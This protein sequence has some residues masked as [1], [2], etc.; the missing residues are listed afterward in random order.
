MSFNFFSW[1][2][3]LRYAV[4]ALVAF[5]GFMMVFVQGNSSAGRILLMIAAIGVFSTM[6]FD[7]FDKHMRNKN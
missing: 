1:W 5:W 7:L 4:C 2:K 3:I 6:A